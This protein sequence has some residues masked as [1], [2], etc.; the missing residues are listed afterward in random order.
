[1]FICL[2]GKETDDGI[3]ALPSKIEEGIDWM[4]TQAYS[5]EPELAQRGARLLMLAGGAKA[6]K[7]LRAIG[8][9]E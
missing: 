6:E 5:G 2:V 8:Y 9:K 4:I 1:M 7:V 3:F